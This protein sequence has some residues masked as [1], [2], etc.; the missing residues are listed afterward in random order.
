MKSLQLA[1]LHSL[2][3][4]NSSFHTQSISYS[5]FLSNL[6]FS[7]QSSWTWELCPKISFPFPRFL[8]SPLKSAAWNLLYL[9]YQRPFWCHVLP[10]YQGICFRHIFSF[11][12]DSP[13]LPG[14]SD[15]LLLSSRISTAWSPRHALPMCVDSP[16]TMT[17][18]DMP[19]NRAFQVAA[20]A[21]GMTKSEV[22]R[23][24]MI[25]P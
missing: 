14:V 22:W 20:K 9:T 24:W 8:V 15:R 7:C 6:P 16:L 3:C 17:F 19:H 1:L 5:L 13:R 11:S 21:P 10:T 12:S 4:L 25:T 23:E 18:S 2:F